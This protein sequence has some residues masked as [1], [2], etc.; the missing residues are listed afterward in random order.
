METEKL[1][2]M[3]IDELP[4]AYAPYSNFCVSAALLCG[5]GSVYTGTN[6]ENASY[7]PTVC[8]ERVAFFKAVNDG[9]RDFAA[10]V[11][12]GGKNGAICRYCAPCGVCRQVMQEFCDPDSFR[13][14]IARSPADYKEYLLKELLPEGFAGANLTQEIE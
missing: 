6:I 8:G 2:Q 12:C 7:T 5:D 3:A 9:K 13:I 11:V 14:L 4:H 1:I 10:I